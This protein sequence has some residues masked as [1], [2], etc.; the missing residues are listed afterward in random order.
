M[1]SKERRRRS[2]VRS[3]RGAGGMLLASSLLR[4]K[5]SM[6][7]RSQ[8]DCLVEG[9]GWRWM[10]AKDQWARSATV[11]GASVMG[12][13]SIWK[14]ALVSATSSWERAG[15]A[16]RARRATR[17]SAWAVPKRGGGARGAGG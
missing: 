17:Q 16:P 12:V 13:V 4:M 9:R 3:A 5:A 6:G 14:L 11:M 15:A 2:V 7:L 8:A 10:G 1:R